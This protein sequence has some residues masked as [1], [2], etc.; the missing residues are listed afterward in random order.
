MSEGLVKTLVSL[1]MSINENLN[2]LYSI[3]LKIDPLSSNLQVG[4]KNQ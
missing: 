4:C 1:P 2:I 3:K